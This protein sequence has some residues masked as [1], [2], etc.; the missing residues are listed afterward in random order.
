MI[1]KNHA[2]APVK[3]ERWSPTTRARKEV[4]RNK[5]VEKGRVSDRVERFQEV[6]R[7][8][9]RSRANLG[10]LNSFKME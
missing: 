7:S 10:L 9:N 4:S 1:L 2:S 6:D 5:F 8:K 3:K